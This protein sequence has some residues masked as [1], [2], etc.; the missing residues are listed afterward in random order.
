MSANDERGLV[1]KVVVIGDGVVGKTS[2]IRRYTQ[3]EFSDKYIQ[4]L[5]A[6]FTN[7]KTNIDLTPCD[8]IFW[9]IAGQ[10]AYGNLRAN[11]YQGSSAAII[12][13]SQENTEHGIKNIEHVNKWYDDIK[14]HYG[15]IPIILFG[16]KSD[17]ID[18]N[19]LEQNKKRVEIIMNQ[20][21]FLGSYPTSALT[22]DGV[23]S[24]FD[25]LVKKLIELHKSFA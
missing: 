3:G 21:R 23:I 18:K 10:E 17:L 22:G 11:F 4:T 15:S 12:V 5:G 9:D 25:T 2:L 13:F 19:T 20:Y 8:L 24:A 16:N 14:K 7:F 1:F 6:Q